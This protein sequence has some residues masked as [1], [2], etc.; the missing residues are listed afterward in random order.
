MAVQTINIGAVA[1]DGTG[2]DLR[3]AFI[4]INQNFEELDLRDDE[5]TTASNIGSIGEGIFAN[6][7]NYDLQF[8]KLVGGSNVSLTPTGESIVVNAVGGL[9][10][11]VVSSDNGSIILKD[12]DAVNLVGGSGI[13]TSVLGNTITITNTNSSLVTD[14]TPQLGGNL[15]AQNF[16]ISNANTIQSST[17]QGFLNGNVEGNVWDIDIRTVDSR[18][19]EA[20]QIL[21]GFELGSLSSNVTSLLEFL[22]RSVDIEYGTIVSPSP[23]ISDFGSI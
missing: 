1:N 23:T 11:L 21:T 9:Q 8:K 22:A 20:E 16:N 7:V 2:D 17:F 5:Q 15:D 4:K 13:E 14:T 18:L 3:E 6:K 19:D 10:Q 12:G